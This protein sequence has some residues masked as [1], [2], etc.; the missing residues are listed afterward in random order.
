MFRILPLLALALWLNANLF[1]ADEA[2]RVTL[3]HIKLSGAMDEAPVGEDP[4][5]GGGSENFKGKLERIRKAKLDPAV[6]GLLLQIEGVST[7]WGKMDELRGAIAEFRSAGKKAYAYMESAESHDYLVALACDEI[8]LPESG[9]LMVTGLRAEVSFYKDLFE[10][11]DVKADMLQM[12]DFKGAAEP[13]TRSG[14]S[15]QFRKQLESVLDDY[16]DKSVID[17]IA[18][19]RAAKKLSKEQVK[20]LIDEGPYTARAALTAALIDRVSYRDQFQEALKS[21]LKSDVFVKKNYGQAKSEELDLSNPFALLK[22]FAPPKEESN[23]KPKVALIYATGMIVSGKGVDGLL[24][25]KVMGSTTMIDA[26]RKAD[27]DATVKAIVLR[28]DSPGGS[29]L[30]SD[31]IWNELRKSKK[32]VIASMSDVAA[33][34]GYYI[35]T[36]ASKIFAEPGTLTGS[37]GVV[38]GKFVIGGLEK[39][40]GLKTEVISRGANSGILSSNEAFSAA[41]RKAMTALMRDCYEQFLEK[42]LEG[43]KKA[44]RAMSRAELENLA[45]G[46]V[47][48]GRQAKENGLIDELGTLEDALA[49]ARKLAGMGANDVDLLILPKPANFMETLMERRADAQ[50]PALKLESLPLLRMLPELT[51]KLRG[52]EGLLQLRAEPVW[53]VLPGEVKVK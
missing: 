34:G 27:G 19:G 2:K 12:G 36:A 35:S 47:W 53:V 48:T 41:E 40:A 26:I 10:K 16:Y 29:A 11:V 1:A 33:S 37:I 4:F 52:A 5:F 24:G 42:T 39:M 46:R 17:V 13:Y 31:L 15:P 6:Q 23:D 28:V 49:A 44:G 21:E 8:V 3:A 9:W 20:K 38:G 45:G 7:G 22:L 32:P 30:A 51:E 25:G 50:A 43:R 18:Q 14:M